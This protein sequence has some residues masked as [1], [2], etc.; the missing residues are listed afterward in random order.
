MMRRVLPALLVSLAL[1][2]SLEAQD[3]DFALRPPRDSIIAR[4]RSLVVDGEGDAGRKLV[5]SVLA[6][7][8]TDADRYSETLFWRGV[9]AASAADAERSYRRLLIEAPLSERAE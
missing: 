9:L 5:D 1:S 7:S 8:A 4:A 6:A 2:T 3:V